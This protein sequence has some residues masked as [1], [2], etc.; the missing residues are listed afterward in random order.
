MRALDT[1][2][3]FRLITRLVFGLSR[4]RQPILGTEFA[5]RIEAVGTDVRN[6]KIGDPVFA[7]SDTSM[8]CYAEYKCMPERGAV[9]PKPANLSFEEAA[10]VPFGGTTALHFLR[11]A[12]LQSGKKVL[13]NG[14]SGGVGTAAVQLAKY[15]GAEVT[16]VCSTANVDLVRSLGADHVID[17]TKEDFAENGEI[18]DVIADAAGTAPYSRSRASL[19]KGGCLLLLLAGLPEMLS[20]PWVSMTSGKKIVAGPAFGT[21]EDLRFL[22]DLVEKGKFRTVVDRSYPFEQIA[23][24]HRYVDTGH[25][26]GNVVISVAHDD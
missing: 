1:P 19:K 21:V 18:Y 26:K 22:A 25:K 8:G 5:G 7:F 2:R 4:P 13:I 9:V 15:Y 14:A 3:G 12:E 6:F 10:A 24:A 11:K 16:G 23:D 20:I 17:Y